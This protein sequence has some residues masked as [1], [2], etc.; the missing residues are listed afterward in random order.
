MNS[1][2][3]RQL[4]PKPG[5]PKTHGI[6]PFW[7]EKMEEIKTHELAAFWP[8]KIGFGA[9]SERGKKDGEGCGG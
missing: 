1:P 9:A 7:G 2:E 3:K 5:L 6:V 4:R 8:K